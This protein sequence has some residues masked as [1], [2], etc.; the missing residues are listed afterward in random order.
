MATTGLERKSLGD[1]LAAAPGAGPRRAYAWDAARGPKPLW[2]ILGEPPQTGWDGG[3]PATV[4]RT[5]GPNEPGEAPPNPVGPEACREHDPPGSPER[6]IC[7]GAGD[8]SFF[9]CVR[10]CVMDHLRPDWNKDDIDRLDPDRIRWLPID[11]PECF[12]K[13]VNER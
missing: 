6:A 1:I 4:V 9:N 2:A 13:C 5:T 7:E 12:A 10:A 8:N 3:G 11:R